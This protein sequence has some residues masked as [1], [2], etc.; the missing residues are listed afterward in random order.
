MSCATNTTWGNIPRGASTVGRVAVA[1]RASHFNDDGEGWL[2]TGGVSE[3]CQVK[4]T[5]RADL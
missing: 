2:V 5:K 4:A 1:V 3:K